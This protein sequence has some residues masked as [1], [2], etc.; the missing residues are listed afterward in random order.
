MFLKNIE[1]TTK[2]FNEYTYIGRY[3]QY[4]VNIYIKIVIKQYSA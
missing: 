4:I 1:I 3:I 2:V